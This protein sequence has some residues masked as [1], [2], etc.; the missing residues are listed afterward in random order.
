MKKG[1]SDGAI[2]SITYGAVGH[3]T[4]D[5]NENNLDAKLKYAY[6]ALYD[7]QPAE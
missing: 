7:K 3:F 2:D 6:G 1:S 4:S 5:P